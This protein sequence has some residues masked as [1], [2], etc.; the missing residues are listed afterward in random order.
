LN[1]QK[2][3]VESSQ[4]ANY[5][6]NAQYTIY[7]NCPKK[8]LKGGFAKSPGGTVRIESTQIRWFSGQAD[9]RLDLMRGGQSHSKLS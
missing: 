6:I 9:G 3:N 4:N 5:T 1:E 2:K 8:T 7:A